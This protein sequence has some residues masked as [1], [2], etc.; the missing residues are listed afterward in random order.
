MAI[1]FYT[2]SEK[3]NN[4]KDIVLDGITLNVPFVHCRY[5]TLIVFATVFSKA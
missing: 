2:M 5:V 4:Q 3:L 1:S